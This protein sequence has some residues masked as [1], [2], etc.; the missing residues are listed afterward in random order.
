MF[1]KLA[2]TIAKRTVAV[3]LLLISVICASN[4]VNKLWLS[5]GSKFDLAMF[6]VLAVI[7]LLGGMR[8]WGWTYKNIVLGVYFIVFGGVQVAEKVLTWHGN[9]APVVIPSLAFIGVGIFFIKRKSFLNK[10]ERG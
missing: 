7:T 9:I 5:S 3:V 6:F 2:G 8:A 1:G 4:I 10:R